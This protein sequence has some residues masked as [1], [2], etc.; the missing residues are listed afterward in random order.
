MSVLA[1]KENTQE[2]KKPVTVQ[3]F[4]ASVRLTISLLILIAAAAALGTFVPPS[5]DVYHSFWF[6]ALLGLLS[7]NLTACSLERFPVSWRRFSEKTDPD[8]PRSFFDLLPADQ[9]FFSRDE[10]VSEAA[11]VE[12][13]LRKRYRRVQKKQTAEGTFF[14][15]E[16]GA[17]SHFGVYAVHL[18]VLV[19][20]AGAMTGALFG[21]KGYVNIAEGE[22]A[23]AVLLKGEKKLKNLDFAVRLDR[24]TMDFYE[25]G[26]P[27]TYRSDLTFM[28]EG[29]VLYQGPLLV[30]HPI[31]VEGLRFYQSGYGSAGDGEAS[32]RLRDGKK[33]VLKKVRVGDRF[34]IPGA[35]AD[36]R[37]LRVEEDLMGMGP[38]VKVHVR[39]AKKDVQF[40]AFHNIREIETQNPGLFEKVPQ[41]NPGLFAPYV[42]ELQGV[43][44]RYYS[45]L[46]VTRDPGAPV[47]AAGAFLMMVGFMVVFFFAHRRIYVRIDEAEGM[48]RVAVTGSTSRNKLGLERE[49][50]RFIDECRGKEPSGR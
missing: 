7:L 34:E 8:R 42:F 20:I 23:G 11:K 1:N 39:S 5:V 26:M 38:A 49:V 30:N 9:V 13:L 35:K 43:T 3:S 37:V 16:K 33:D 48:T 4:F 15:A 46:Q 29:R 44:V 27:K 12:D 21:F 50:R 25:N 45:G 2:K 28:K 41:F 40:W 14:S 6:L 19:I 24:F 10:K 18:G 47:V 22:T 31:D 32:L 17:F 36:V